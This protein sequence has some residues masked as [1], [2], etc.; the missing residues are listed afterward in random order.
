MYFEVAHIWVPLW[1]PPVVAFVISFFSSMVGVSG[2]FLLVPFQMSVLGY[3]T[4]SVS[5]TNLV[6]NLVAIPGGGLALRPREALGLAAGP[7]NHRGDASGVAGGVVV[8]FTCH[9]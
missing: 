3:V 5:A 7:R 1:V 2:A 9:A 8:A 4:P 6:F